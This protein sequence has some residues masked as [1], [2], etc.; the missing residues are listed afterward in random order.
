[1]H[2][3]GN[4]FQQ[5]SDRKYKLSQK[6]CLIAALDGKFVWTACDNMACTL[7]VLPIFL[8]THTDFRQDGIE[9]GQTGL[10]DLMVDIVEAQASHEVLSKLVAE[11]LYDLS[12]I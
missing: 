4:G 2:V 8:V 1:M 12:I 6:K 10:D 11:F 9:S 3:K 5:K 7:F